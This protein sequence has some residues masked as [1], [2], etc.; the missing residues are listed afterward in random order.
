MVVDP[1]QDGQEDEARDGVEPLLDQEL[2]RVALAER[3]RRGRRAEDHHEPE[4]DEP[5]GDED[6]EPLLELASVGTAFGSHPGS[7]CTSRRNS[8]PRCSKLVNW[9]NEAQAGERRT[10]SSAAAADAASARARSSVPDDTHG[11][12]SF[13][14]ASASVVGGLADQIRAVAR[15]ECRREGVVRLGLAAAPEDHVLAA[16]GERRDRAA[17]G[18]R[19]RR[20]RVVHVEDAVDDRDLFDAV[21]DTGERDECVGDRLVRDSES[22]GSGGRGGRVL[23]VVLAADARLGRQRVVGRELH[24]TR[25]AGHRP[26]AA[27]HHRDIVLPLALEHRQLDRRVGVE[28]PVPVEV[29]GLEVREHGH[30]RRERRDVLQLERGELADDPGV[31]RDVPDE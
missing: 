15:L 6:Q 4:R 3:R 13:R 31:G 2:H 12:P 1:R 19:V 7:F 26:E 18:G 25:G 17:R 24:A 8:S 22:A 28:R 5:E 20:L 10:T 30:P 16:A 21:L 11:T 29:V 14:S 27:R 9:S 23:P